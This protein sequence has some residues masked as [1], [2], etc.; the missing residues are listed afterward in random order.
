MTIIR[1][2]PPKVEIKKEN[3]KLKKKDI[4]ILVSLVAI[5]ICLSVTSLVQK[6]PTVDEVS[7]HI[8]TGYVFLKTRDFAYATDT[9]PLGRYIVGAPLLCMNLILP[10]NRDFWARENQSE[11]SQKFLYEL[12]RKSAVDIVLFPRLMTVIVGVFGGVFLFFWMKK[13]FDKLTA[14]ITVVFYFLSPNI[15]AHARL[16]TT[17]M[18][19][20]V[21]VMCSI[22]TFWTFIN[23]IN[24]KNLI[25]SSFFLALALMSKYFAVLLLPVFLIFMLNVGIYHRREQGIKRILYTYLV[26]LFIALLILW[27]G[28]LFEFKPFLK[29][30]SGANQKIVMFKKAIKFLLPAVRMSTLD[31]FTRKIFRTPVPLGSYVYGV[32]GAFKHAYEGTRSF[33][34]G[35]W[36]S[37]GDLSYY[38][39][40]F[41]IKTPV[42]VMASFLLGLFFGV[43]NKK[44]RTLYL[45][46][47]TIIFVYVAFASHSN[48]Q[49]GLRFILL[50]YPLIFII[51]ATAITIVVKTENIKRI[52]MVILTLWMC[53]INIF[54]W[55][56]YI[57]YFNE[58]IGGP[59]NGYK[60]LRDSNLDWGQDLPGLKAYMDKNYMDFVKLDYYGEGDPSFYGINYDKVN[61][62]E[63]HAPE[64]FVYAISVNNIDNYSWV[65]SRNPDAVIGYSIFIYDLRKNGK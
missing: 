23:E 33:F 36:S 14:L 58:L 15:I 49:V 11:F 29:N 3:K 43:R 1:E 45:Y 7:R 24:L 31:D 26:Y 2:E 54:I 9:P 44:I 61:E 8:P 25:I 13:N 37:K 6:S 5:F 40:A 42:P 39:T 12:N 34:M 18:V 17:D 21:A 28:Y 19:A 51:A 52:L 20:T 32:L 56:D 53:A 64:D 38:I 62:L 10:E 63:L 55:P 57:A 50:I 59:S 30:V 16:A 22:L 4:V 47:L 48:F 60:F 46:F 41:L 27:I 35:Q 65:Q